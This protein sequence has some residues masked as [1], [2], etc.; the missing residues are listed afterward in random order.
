[1]SSGSVAPRIAQASMRQKDLKLTTR[2][3][4]DPKFLDVRGALGALPMLSL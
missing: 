3:Y 2:V 1:M 4:T